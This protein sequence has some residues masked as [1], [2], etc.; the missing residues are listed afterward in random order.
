MCKNACL[1]QFVVLVQQKDHT[2]SCA[3]LEGGAW[4]IPST[5]WEIKLKRLYSKIPEIG[6]KTPLQHWKTKLS[7]GHP[8]EMFSGSAH[9]VTNI[10][11]IN[12]LAE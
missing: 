11:Y 8:L 3:D 10:Q 12:F 7:L 1:I 5:S 9:A 2:R 4:T 6:L